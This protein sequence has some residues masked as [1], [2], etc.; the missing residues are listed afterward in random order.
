MYFQ[1]DQWQRRQQSIGAVVL[2]AVTGWP[3]RVECPLPWLLAALG[4]DVMEAVEAAV[5]V[6]A[7]A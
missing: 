4:D 6:L 7:A 2:A 5:S 1:L 3:P